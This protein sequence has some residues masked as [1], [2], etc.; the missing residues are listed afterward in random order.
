V[1]R[2]AIV[3]GW[4]LLVIAGGVILRAI[5]GRATREDWSSRSGYVMSA[6]RLQ[7]DGAP[8]IVKGKGLAA[9]KRRR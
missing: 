6:R 8:D 7:M 5:L 4:I 2:V 1:H 3:L 9:L